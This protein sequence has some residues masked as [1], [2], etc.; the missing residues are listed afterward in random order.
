M[1][2]E[3]ANDSGK[4]IAPLKW[5]ILQDLRDVTFNDCSHYCLPDYF[6]NMAWYPDSDVTIGQRIDKDTFRILSAYRSSSLLDLIIENRGSWRKLK[7]LDILDTSVASRRRN[8]IQK[9]LLRSNLPVTSPD[10]PKHFTDG[11]ERHVDTN[12]KTGYAWLHLL[13]ESM[14]ATLNYTISDNWGYRLKNGSY[15]GMTG[16]LHRKEID[17]SGSSLIFLHERLEAA[18]F[19]GLSYPTRLVFIFREPPLSFEN[20]LYILPFSRS[21]WMAT[22]IL[23]ALILVALILSTKWD[24]RSERIKSSKKPNVSDNM[25]IVVGAFAQ[26]GFGLQPRSIP[27]YVILLVLLASAVNLYTSY[28]ANIAALLRSTS[29]SIQGLKDLLDSPFE[30]GSEDIVYSRRIFKVHTD[31]VRRAIFDQKVETKSGKSNWLPSK[32]G[33]ERLRHGSFAFNM[34]AG[35]AYKIIQDTFEEHEKCGLHEIRSLGTFRPTFAITKQSPYGEIFRVNAMKIE[36][37]GLKMREMARLYTQ[38][39]VCSG[40]SNSFVSVGIRECHFPIYIVMCGSMLSIW[41]LLMEII[42]KRSFRTNQEAIVDD[43][44]E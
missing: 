5:L 18:Q 9:T 10:T 15:D 17:V 40:S 14:N 21:L 35:P 34:E 27:S 3:Q 31:P 43:M 12:S 41:F 29:D 19:I 25:L 13:V 4:F 26:Q 1:S 39:P 42:W 36:E 30:C 23:L 33:I 20:N 6:Q 24:W 16:Y 8:N 44:P 22:G 11:L 28:S 2:F 7:G 37:R 38:K 32:E